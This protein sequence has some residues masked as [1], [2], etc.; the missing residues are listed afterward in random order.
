MRRKRPSWLVCVLLATLLAGASSLPGCSRDHAARR[1]ARQWLDA[2]EAAMPGY[3]E[4]WY[5]WLNNNSD[6]PYDNHVIVDVRVDWPSYEVGGVIP[7]VALVK[8]ASCQFLSSNSDYF[9]NEG[10]YIEVNFMRFS[11]YNFI[12][13]ANAAPGSKGER[14]P[15]K[16]TGLDLVSA[17][18]SG[19]M[20][21]LSDLEPLSDVA[22][23][24]LQGHAIDDITAFEG[25]RNLK[26]LWVWPALSEDDLEYLETIL[27]GC[28]IKRLSD[29]GVENRMA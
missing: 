4:V 24:E 5:V 23:M 12:R 20:L 10:Y 6:L 11:K 1:Q 16:K 9:L 26:E 27:P 29:A 3:M 2:L 15:P 8:E 14:V 28:E 25:Y 21:G 17:R 18:V 22:F 13:L 7:D 19:D